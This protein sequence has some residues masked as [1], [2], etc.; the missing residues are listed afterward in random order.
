MV[1]DIEDLE[2][3]PQDYEWVK[4]RPPYKNAFLTLL[5]TLLI[6][7]GLG[8]AITLSSCVERSNPPIVLNAPGSSIEKETVVY[9]SFKK[10]TLANLK[11]MSEDRGAHI[12][13]ITFF[14][15]FLAQDKQSGIGRVI[16]T[17]LNRGGYTLIMAVEIGSKLG[18]NDTWE[19][20]SFNVIKSSIVKEPA[21]GGT[22]DE[23]E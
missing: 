2:S 8:G 21:D 6:L 12:Q 18:V 3:N 9:A 4:K 19:I 15:G 7:V 16:F 10:A 20:S 11:K 14:Q 13:E 17:V 5:F 23:E 22:A 1:D